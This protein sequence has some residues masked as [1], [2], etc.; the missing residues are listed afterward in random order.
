M[1]VVLD[2]NVL[3]SGLLTRH[4]NCARILELVV[5]GVLTLCLDGRIRSEYT[6]VCHEP[7]LG[8]DLGEVEEFL[9]FCAHYAESI[10]AHPLAAVLP[11]ASDLPF[12]EVTV[13]AGAVLVTGNVKHFPRRAIGATA[14]VTPTELLT[15]LQSKA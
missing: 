9:R 6:R 2:T 13:S 11:D 14:V 4:G 12:L 3:V 10:T 8:L 5:E 7:R 1:K 15:L